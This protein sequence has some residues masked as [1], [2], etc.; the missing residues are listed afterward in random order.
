MRD[1]NEK[2][3]SDQKQKNVVAVGR[4]TDQKGFD[5]LIKSFSLIEN[6]GWK[7][8]IY[9]EDKSGGRYKKISGKDC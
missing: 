8:N 6:D 5:T 2:L 3:I 4:L 9:G 1:F 7:L